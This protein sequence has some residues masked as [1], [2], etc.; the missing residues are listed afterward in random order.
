MKPRKV[1]WLRSKE[2]DRKCH[3]RG[4]KSGLQ[5]PQNM[6]S[7]VYQTFLPSFF[8]NVILLIVTLKVWSY[9]FV[10]VCNF[11]LNF[12]RTDTETW[13]WKRQR[14]KHR[15]PKW[16]NNSLLLIK[17]DFFL[18]GAHGKNK[19]RRISDWQHKII[20]ANDRLLKLSMEYIWI[21]K[22]YRR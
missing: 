12:Y 19:E 11:S 3:S 1:I 15:T 22:F 13:H 4:L 2:S 20:N 14:P 21:D 6:H 17:L 9:N 8:P 16:K 7:S 18:K 5:T 10:H